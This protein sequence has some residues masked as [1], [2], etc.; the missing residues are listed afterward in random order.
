[1]DKTDADNVRRDMNEETQKALA[2]A[3]TNAVEA[4]F[5]LDPF[6]REA[7]REFEEILE[8]KE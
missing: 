6:N 8:A 7:Q 3:R 5:E 2:E 4:I 1:M